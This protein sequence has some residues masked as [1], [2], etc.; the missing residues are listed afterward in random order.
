MT[1]LTREEEINLAF[2]QKA[3]KEKQEKAAA[4][5]LADKELEHQKPQSV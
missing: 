5:A 3:E 1:Q 2:E 4:W